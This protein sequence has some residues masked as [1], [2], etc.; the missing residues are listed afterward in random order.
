MLMSGDFNHKTEA[1]GWSVFGFEP[2]WTSRKFREWDFHGFPDFLLFV[3]VLSLENFEDFIKHVEV[4]LQLGSAG[5]SKVCG[6]GRLWYLSKYGLKIMYL[7]FLD[8]M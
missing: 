1:D 2:L 7:G 3:E 8:G 6:G 4:N 5:P